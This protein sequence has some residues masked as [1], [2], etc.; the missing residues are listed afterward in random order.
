MEA[1]YP[2]PDWSVGIAEVGR[3]PGKAG[4][5]V[6]MENELRAVHELVLYKPSRRTFIEF[7]ERFDIVEQPI[8]LFGGNLIFATQF[9]GHDVTFSQLQH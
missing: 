5:F 1:S 7:D 9:W 4:D 6:L 2:E 8:E 3:Y